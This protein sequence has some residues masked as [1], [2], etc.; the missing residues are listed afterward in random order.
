MAPSRTRTI[1]FVMAV[2][3][4]ALALRPVAPLERVL[5]LALLPGRVLAALAMPL[6]ALAAREGPEAR[7][8]RATRDEADLEAHRALEARVR[9]AAWPDDGFLG[10]HI[11]AVQ[12][13]VIGHADDELD[14]LRL[15]VSEPERVQVGQP[16]VAGDAYVGHVS[17]IPGREPPPPAPRGLL[18]R[19]ARRLG[20][21]ARVAEHAAN[22][23]FVELVTAREARIGARI[24]EAADGEA[25]RVV[26][27]GLAP[28]PG[29]PFLAVHNPE[30]STARGVVRVHEPESLS[31]VLSVL[32]D[33][34]RI[35]ELCTRAAPIEGADFTREL[36]GVDPFLDYEAGLHQV[37][38]LTA[39]GVQERT[40]ARAR[41][42]LTDGN[43]LDARFI[44]RS[45]P[46]PWRA[47]RKLD[48]GR[49]HG[50]EAGA[51]VVS[52]ARLVGR[53]ARAGLVTSD[54]VLPGDVGFTFSALAEPTA[55]AGT[56]PAENGAGRAPLV[57]G[58]FVSRG[59]EPGGALRFAWRPQ[60]SL[61]GSDAGD[62]PVP[63]LEVT[64]WTGS[65]EPGVPRGLLVGTALL[66]LGPG[67]HVV[68]VEQCEGARDPRGLAVRTASASEGAR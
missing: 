67:P 43:W 29:A 48:R 55:A 34:F 37:L 42:V 4:G 11:G 41:T 1:G 51:A 9:R 63:M 59:R 64:L 26:V 60:R 23:V 27:G 25:S 57:L 8:L 50:V 6:G 35:G 49:R 16:V 31:N 33:T 28:L 22:V 54:V 18:E 56:G 39:D 61:G 52:G 38:V 44:V 66:P 21:G 68:L 10:P 46:A 58:R 12:A 36:L 3:S 2:A 53:V 30:R 15:A 17:R 40:P 5:D 24:D 62:G 20:L 14:L 65:G 47:G 13:E 32:A 7:A 45:E 19:V